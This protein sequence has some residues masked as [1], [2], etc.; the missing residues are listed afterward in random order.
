[1]NSSN[2]GAIDTLLILEKR[3]ARLCLTRGDGGWTGARERRQEEARQGG[4]NKAGKEEGRKEEGSD[5]RRR[6]EDTVGLSILYEMR[7][8]VRLF[9]MRKK[10][11]DANDG[12]HVVT[13]VS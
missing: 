1:M 10:T 12:Y 5:A 3:A 4:G 2:L 11:A 8:P 7:A 6:K 9:L 13:T